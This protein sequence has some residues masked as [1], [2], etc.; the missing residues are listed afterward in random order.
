VNPNIVLGENVKF[1]NALAIPTGLNLTAAYPILSNPT[2]SSTA[3]DLNQDVIVNG[4]NLL[5]EINALPE[6][7]NNG[8]A[9]TQT[10]NGTLILITGSEHIVLTPIRVTQAQPEQSPSIE[11]H[12][13]GSVS[14]ITESRRE[15]LAQPAVEDATALQTEL[16]KLGLNTMQMDAEGTLK[17]PVSSQMYYV[18][19]A[20]KITNVASAFEPLGLLF[21]ASPWLK[22]NQLAALHFVETEGILR[23]QQI[24]YP[25]AAHP[26]ELWQALRGIPGASAVTFNN[27]GTIT[28]KVNRQTYTAVFD[29]QVQQGAANHVPQMLFIA[30]QNGDGT[31][32]IRMIYTNG[33][34]QIIYLVPQPAW[35]S[36]L[37]FI[38]D[39]QTLGLSVTQTN[40]GNLLFTQDI[41]C[42][43]PC[44][45]STSGIRSLH[46]VVNIQ[47]IDDNTPMS[48]TVNPD[49]SALFI[50][51]SG[52]K[53]TTQPLMQDFAGLQAGLNKWGLQVQAEDNGQLAIFAGNLQFS[54]RPALISTLAPLSSAI[55]VYLQP[56]SL[57]N[58]NNV[59]QI[60]RDDTGTKRQQWLYPAARDTEAL[61][62]FLKAM[63]KVTSVAL[64]NDGT[65][66]INKQDSKIHGVL[67]YGLTAGGLATGS[68][69]FTQGTDFNGDGLADYL[70]TY[71]DGLKQ[72]MYQLP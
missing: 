70:I 27:N 66:L 58:V 9:Y 14:F 22:N 43:T 47:Q 25:T 13:D 57:P 37:P 45:V 50:T 61:N 8:L 12:P 17:M 49:G 42:V 15:I 68:V 53:I 39:M 19:R 59:L 24:L 56:S 34:R 7:S 3:I 69:Q 67:D 30:D 60:F 38:P 62:Q 51:D 18:A 6:L 4:K 65:I 16:Q 46:Q 40:D 32:D 2:L 23:R 52:R 11:Q 71:A 64:N 10:A 5:Q 33:D 55:G 26:T 54:A 21:T 1:A 31:E 72:I 20:D 29:Y 35:L 63:P 36:E 28:V 44:Q 48:V 41:A